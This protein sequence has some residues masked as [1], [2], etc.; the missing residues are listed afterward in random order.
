MF[1]Q[2][3]IK[4]FTKIP[5]FIKPF[6]GPT[7]H[8]CYGCENILPH[9]YDASP[10]E[11][12][13]ATFLEYEL[14]ALSFSKYYLP[15]YIL[16][17][18]GNLD[19]T[20]IVKLSAT[21]GSVIA[22]TWF[23][24]G[25]SRSLDTDYKRL[26]KVLAENDKE[27]LKKF[28][29]SMTHWPS[30]YNVNDADK[31]V[32]KLDLEEIKFK[33]IKNPLFSVFG[34][35]LGRTMIM[36]G[37]LGFIQNQMQPHFLKFRKAFVEKN[38]AKRLKI[39]INSDAF[40]DSMFFDNRSK[41]SNGRTLVICSEGNAAFYEVGIV[42]MPLTEGFSVIGWNRPGF[43]ESKGTTNPQNERD[44]IKA[45]IEYS[46]FELKFDKIILFGWS[47]GGYPTAVGSNV[48]DKD[49]KAIISGMI[50]DATFDH[51]TPLAGVVLPSW[52]QGIASGV[53]KQEWDLDVSREA[54]KFKGPIVI[55]RRL[56]DEILSTG[57]P[58]RPDLNRANWLLYDVVQ[59]RY[60]VISDETMGK[61]RSYVER[62]SSLIA[63]DEYEQ[64]IFKFVKSRFID[65][66]SGHNEPLP[67]REFR[68]IFSE[69]KM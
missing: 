62:G 58:S 43:A 12:I 49:G 10:V 4:I 64:M 24:L 65:V 23:L 22:A 41:G 56:R 63:E 30:D 3:Y 31:I 67:Q 32:N 40:I 7:Y 44:A 27:K 21:F 53:V 29:F 47:I 14:W 8:Q 5:L 42:S 45:L 13:S 35:T 51:I 48:K 18:S 52:F 20:E 6:F 61:V 9:N 50:L 1:Q 2:L 25:I 69:G 37:C 55:I 19:L 11:A 54:C 15:Y 28:D 68:M 60:P 66:A 36:P 38:K 46:K 59:S 39:D 57:G 16:T 33:G 26:I 17:R 34:A